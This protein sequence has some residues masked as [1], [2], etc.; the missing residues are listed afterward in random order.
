MARQTF[1]GDTTA[2]AMTAVADPDNTLKLAR[3]ATGITTW[4]A[5]TG[6][7]QVTDLQNM[8]G[9][10]I[11][12]VSTDA[13]GGFQFKGPDEIYQ[14][15]MDSGIGARQL[16]I[17]Q[18]GSSAMA[19]SFAAKAD[20]GHTH[21]GTYIA[22]SEKAA[23]SGVASLNSSSQVPDS[24]LAHPILTMADG[25]SPPSVVNGAILFVYDPNAT[26]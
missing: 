14:L 12:T 20:L 25:G 1:G 5:Q 15:W 16:A 21:T 23:A 4:T 7:T 3:N 10:A 8:A 13:N 9:G 19:A 22:S 26:L 6:G 2:I 24:Q 11:T 17:S 18:A